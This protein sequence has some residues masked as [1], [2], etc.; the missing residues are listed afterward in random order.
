MLHK[1]GKGVINRFFLSFVYKCIVVDD[2]DIK[3]G[4]GIP[5]NGLTPP[6]IINLQRGG[7]LF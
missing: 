4:F 2:P 6:V 5:L 1:S 3:R 7:K